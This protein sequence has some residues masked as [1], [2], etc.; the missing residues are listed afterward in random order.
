MSTFEFAYRRASVSKLSALVK[1]GL[2]VGDDIE[3][4]KLDGEQEK[5]V[6]ELSEADFIRRKPVK[7]EVPVVELDEVLEHEKGKFVL[8]RMLSDF[9]FALVRKDFDNSGAENPFPA[10]Y[11]VTVEALA[12]ALTPKIGNSSA[13]RKTI[14]NALLDEIAKSFASYLMQGGR[15]ASAIQYQLGYLRN[16]FD[17]TVMASVEEANIIAISTNIVNWAESL[18]DGELASYADAI[19]LLQENLATSLE[20]T[21]EVTADDL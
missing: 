8:T 6:T 5:F 16:R 2:K 1:D 13:K 21:E 7:L 17:P 15:K 18:S 11:A 19:E 4:I 9:I 20:S 12:D 3:L 14:K 10:N